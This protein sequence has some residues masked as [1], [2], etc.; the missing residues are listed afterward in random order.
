MLSPAKDWRE[1]M[2]RQFGNSDYRGGLAGL[3]DDYAGVAQSG[4]LDALVALERIGTRLSLSRNDEIYAEGDES[5][6]WYKVVSGTVRICKLLADGRRHIAEF[7]FLGECFGLDS[8][9]ERRYAAEAVTQRRDQVAS[10]KTVRIRLT[11]G[12]AAKG[13]SISSKTPR[14]AARSLVLASRRPEISIAGT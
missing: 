7:C 6:Y 12:P 11:S 9:G 2:Y 3:A 13:L 14:R 10:A 4:Q 5:D 8:P 1:T